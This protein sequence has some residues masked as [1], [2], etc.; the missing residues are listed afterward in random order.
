MNFQSTVFSLLKKDFLMEWRNKYAI[1]GILLY[2]FCIVFI[3][4]IT[5]GPAMRGPVWI[6]LF[7]IVMLF[8]AVNAVAK[9]F[10][11]ESAGRQLY[12]YTLAHPQAIMMAKIIYNICVMLFLSAIALLFYSATA[13][14]PM[15]D[16][17]SFMLSLILGAIA[18]ASVFSMISAIASKASNSG[19]L[20]AILS[21]PLLIPLLIILIRISLNA[22]KEDNPSVNF[23]DLLY[24]SGLNVL[25]IALAMVLFPYLWRD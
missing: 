4:F 25:V 17:V 9:S 7:W 15:V 21:F 11:Q 22:I 19:T 1:S 14:Y 20:M 16:D 10:M 3:I 2:M 18:F 8:T 5:F 24:L 23:Q 6:V 13:G 12:Y